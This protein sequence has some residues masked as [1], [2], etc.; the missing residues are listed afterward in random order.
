MK[1]SMKKKSVIKIRANSDSL[2]GVLLS[3]ATGRF[4]AFNS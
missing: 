4:P 3:P 1:K 2:S